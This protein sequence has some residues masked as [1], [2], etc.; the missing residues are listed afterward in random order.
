MKRIVIVIFISL[1]FFQPVYCNADTFC[2]VKYLSNYD[3]DTIR[4]DLGENLPPIFR[5]IPLRLQGIDTPEIKGKTEDERKKALIVKQF[6][7]DELSSAKQI[8]LINCKKD[9][10]FRINCQVIY[11]NKNLTDILLEKK[12]GY[13]Y[14][15]EKK[16]KYKM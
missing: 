16:L 3:G 4:F 9:K 14:W 13:E 2:N 12:Y 5:Y 10:Y 6:V 15:G 11:D 8:D 7:K 1:I